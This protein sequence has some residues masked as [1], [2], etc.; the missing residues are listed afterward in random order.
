MDQEPK[1]MPPAGRRPEKMT[2]RRLVRG[3]LGL[4]VLLALALAGGDA[5]KAFHL[6]LPGPVI[7][8][9]LLA[10]I[11]L[12]VERLPAWSHRCLTL[13]LMP[14]SRLLVSHMGLL[15][16]PAGVG[17]IAQGAALRQEWLPIVAALIGSTLIGL[18]AAGW[19]MHCFAPQPP[20][21]KS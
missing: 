11:F 21:S 1:A 9:A 16:V 20:V 7:G 15:F 4:F 17:I 2:K 13:H 19:L 6:A 14:V 5:R 8:L 18:V 12:L 3:L 10:A